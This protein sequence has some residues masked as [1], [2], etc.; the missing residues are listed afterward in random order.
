MHEEQAEAREEEGGV[1]EVGAKE[2]G[3][4]PPEIH[5]T[6]FLANLGGQDEVAPQPSTSGKARER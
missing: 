3:G 1:A 5:Y 4:P 6:E 2:K